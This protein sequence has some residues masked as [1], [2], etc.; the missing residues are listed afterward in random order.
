MSAGGGAS[1][2]EDWLAQLPCAIGEVLI[3]RQSGGGFLLLHRDDSERDDLTAH[4]SA[5]AAS[6]LARYDDAGNYR[7]LKTAP[8]LRHGWSLLLDSREQV[9][10]ALDLFYPGRVA[11]YK[12][13]LTGG[14]TTTSFR[15]TLS[16]QTGMY[17]VAARITDDQADELIGNFCRSDGGCLR[18]ILWRRDAAGTVPSTLL[19]PQKFDPAHDQTGRGERAIP[20]LCQEI[21]NLVVAGARQMVKGAE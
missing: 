3:Q 7:P 11:A 15:E 9:R 14:L 8:N 16:R 17:R 21:C 2:T 12:A 1:A 10:L 6:E 5:D 4:G 19:P 18:T 20:L 13:W